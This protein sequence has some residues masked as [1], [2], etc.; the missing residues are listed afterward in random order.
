MTHI[1]HEINL[2]ISECQEFG[3]SQE[4][5]E[6][7]EESQGMSSTAPTDGGTFSADPALTCSQPA[8]PTVD[9]SWTSVAQKTGLRC[10]SRSSRAC[11]AMA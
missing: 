10:R 9:T 7:H 6:R 4:E 1:R 2:H 5:M 11:W 3:I 8:L